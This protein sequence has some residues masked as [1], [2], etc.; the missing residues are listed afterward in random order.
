MASFKD[1]VR[2]VENA[3]AADAV[4]SSGADKHSA[5][6]VNGAPNPASG[7]KVSV[8]F[9]SVVTQ[10]A[11]DANVSLSASAQK[12][13]QKMV[14]TMRA[15]SAL[16]KK[17][18]SVE[19]DEKGRV[20]A[21]LALPDFTAEGMATV[22]KHQWIIGVVVPYV[23]MVIM[24]QLIGIYA[25]G[26]ADDG[27]SLPDDYKANLATGVNDPLPR[28]ISPTS[29]ANPSG[30]ALYFT[31]AQWFTVVVSGLG[32]EIVLGG[33]LNETAARIG[34]VGIALWHG[35]QLFFSLFVIIAFF[36]QSPFGYPFLV[37]GLW[38]FGFPETVGNF[39]CAFQ[40]GKIDWHSIRLW[41]DAMGTLL[42]HTSAAWNIVGNTNHIFPMS[43]ANIQIGLP[44]MMQHVVVLFKYHSV[45]FY[46]ACELAL[47][48]FWEWEIFAALNLLTVENRWHPSARG[49]GLQM[50]FAHWLY[51]GSALMAVPTMLNAARKARAKT[52][53][54]A[55]EEELHEVEEENT[56]ERWQSATVSART[57][58]ES[59]VSKTK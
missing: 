31:L 55:N 38:K 56:L 26:Q 49:T 27:W 3:E 53:G 59:P 54:E 34:K 32:M 50:I 30:F 23:L 43:R 37:L 13:Y 45:P 33:V 15:N 48:I 57:P 7:R 29:N 47:E 1:V 58:D 6:A 2:D 39:R 52:P 42:H 41:M 5:E 35:A 8:G 20:R 36:S 44:L 40:R 22:R 46:A 51:W 18:M 11:A 4:S 19:V 9:S 24:F 10:A 12:K 28:P 16:K 14:Q 17:D 21:K 25:W